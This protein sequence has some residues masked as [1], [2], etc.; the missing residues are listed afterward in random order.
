ME[1]DLKAQNVTSLTAIYAGTLF[2]MAIVHWG[3]E[4][5]FAVSLQL[6]QQT[7]VVVT[8]TGFSGVLSN[9]LP[10]SVKHQ[11]VYFR[12]RNVLS[13]HRCRRI[14]IKDPRLR[15]S[16]LEGRWPTLFLQEM[17]ESEQNAYWYN[18]IYRPVRS[19]PGVVQAHRSFLLFRDAAAGLFVLLLGLLLWRAASEF[20][21]VM[22]LSTW[23]VMILVGV[24]LLLCQ[25]AR[26]SG[27]RLVVNAV[28]SALEGK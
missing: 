9:F 2:L 3:M 26:Q 11:L 21:P 7:L 27:N 6:G 18:E 12:F 1:K 14:C 17:S 4:E 23:S 16:D 28:A 19:D 15:L 20:A 8:I 22:A 5:V 25:A 10:N 24:I 13:G